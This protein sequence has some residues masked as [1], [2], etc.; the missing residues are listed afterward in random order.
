MAKAQQI[1][2]VVVPGSWGSIR[3][4]FHSLIALLVAILLAGAVY[5][6]R[7]SAGPLYEDRTTLRKLRDDDSLSQC[8]LFSGKWVFDNKSY[9]LYKEK[10]CTFMS[11][12]LACQKFGRTDLSYQQWRWQPHHC[13]L[14][15][16]NATALLER[17]RH[18][19]LVFVGDSLNRGQWVSMVCLVETAI[20]PKLKSMHT[21]GSLITFKATEYNAS[22]EF[23]WAP[24]LVESNSD[25]PVAHRLPDRIVRAQSI[26][27]HAKF[28][29][30]ADIL[31]FNS[32]LWWRRSNMKV[33]WGSFQDSDGIYKEIEML[34][35][36]EMAM[37]TWSDW[38]EIHVNRSKTQLFFTSMS[39]THERAEEWGNS[40]D[41]NCYNETEPILKE[42]YSGNGSDPKMM[43]IVE[44]A[45]DELK[46]RG[47]KV[48]MINI[49]QLT[50][51]RKEGHPSIYRK[52]WD[53]LTEEQISKPTSYA[54]CIH[55]CLPGVPD[56]M[57]ITTT[58]PSQGGQKAR[59][60]YCDPADNT[61]KAEAAVREQYR[62]TLRNATQG[63]G[64]GGRAAV[65]AFAA[66]GVAKTAPLMDL[67]SSPLFKGCD[68]F[69]GAWVYDNESYPIYRDS[70]CKF[71]H[72]DL[73]CEKYG[74]KDLN[75]QH[76]R[77]QPHACSLPR[78]FDAK[79]L[80]DRLRGKRLVFVGDSVNRNQWVSMV[81]L[82][83]SAITDPKS[84]FKHNNGSLYSFKAT[85]YNATI[86][87]YWAP[88]L[89]ESSA[90]NPSRHYSEDRIIRIDSIEKHARHWSG[91]DIL[92]FNSYAWWRLPTLKV[93]AQDWG[94]PSVQ[95]CLNETDPV[96]QKGYHGSS[97]DPILM[98][99]LERE[100]SNLKSRG[101]EVHLLNITQLT[102]YRKDAH[103]SI[104]RK[105]WRPLPKEKLSNPSSYSDC[106]HWCLP[107]VPDVWNELLHAYILYNSYI[108]DSS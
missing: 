105:Q 63:G 50:E 39:P 70:E 73:A 21:N 46:A 40:R 33:L 87:F 55:W 19:R 5:F 7:D 56:T 61:G 57:D 2:I 11:D 83:E 107:G 27:K 48:Q 47:L 86:D 80:L 78:R 99:I 35:S 14:P 52:Q 92:V 45:I 79:A 44:A 96:T 3:C 20:P 37:K 74:R 41:Q 77:W 25:D 76:W 103:P 49:T 65:Y 26:E 12:Q 8:N 101:L 13:D 9:P 60:R 85:E 82:L 23:Y 34:R 64:G 59:E 94:M 53:P 67:T 97:T 31:V 62:A 6:S 108:R 102:E 22:I 38:L 98:S 104:Y 28:W 88:L 75:Y 66:K 89:V 91:A 72:D 100:I 24:L 32:Y 51:Y 58:T 95:N 42:G 106:T 54:D 4:S 93:L 68:L 17:L 84:K 69:S 18:K 71:M 15:R 90:D 43:R 29:T 16:F 81:C 30:D 36:Y 10:E 1:G